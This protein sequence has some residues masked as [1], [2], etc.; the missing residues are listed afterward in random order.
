M[1]IPDFQSIMLPLM[2]FASDRKGHSIRTAVDHLSTAF[3]LT[4]AEKQ[5]L[6]PSGKQPVFDMFLTIE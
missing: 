3:D 2:L 5:D 4:D 6:L 1:T